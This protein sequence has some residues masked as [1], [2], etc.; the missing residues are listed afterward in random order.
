ME[1]ENKEEIIEYKCPDC[2]TV[3]KYYKKQLDEALE[4]SGEVVIRAVCGKCGYK[5]EVIYKQILP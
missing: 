5:S 2:S 1:A 4:Q 3:S